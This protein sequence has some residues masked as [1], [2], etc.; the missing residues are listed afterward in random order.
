MFRA[1]EPTCSIIH[2]PARS[3]IIR[4]LEEIQGS[5]TPHDSIGELESGIGTSV[6]ASPGASDDQPWTD[7]P[8]RLD[9]RPSRGRSLRSSSST[10]RI[11]RVQRALAW[12]HRARPQRQWQ[13]CRTDQRG[14]GTVCKQLRGSR[15]LAHTDAARYL[16]DSQGPRPS[17]RDPGAPQLPNREKIRFDVTEST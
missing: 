14:T 3:V 15:R 10:E 11:G 12:I 9:G 4:R 17:S 8:F 13:R 5:S 16:A 2:I 7:R 1:L 6:S